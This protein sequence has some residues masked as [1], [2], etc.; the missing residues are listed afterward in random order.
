[1]PTRIVTL[2]GQEASLIKEQYNPVDISLVQLNFVVPRPSR[3]YRNPIIKNN[4]PVL[5]TGNASGPVEVHKDRRHRRARYG[6]RP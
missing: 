2:K 4:Q 6:W 5:Q 1:M 3:Y